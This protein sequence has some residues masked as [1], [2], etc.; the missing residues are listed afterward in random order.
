MNKTVEKKT[1]KED[2]SDVVEETEY[3]RRERKKREKKERKLERKKS[4]VDRQES[5]DANSD[6]PDDEFS[7]STVV[8]THTDS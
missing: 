6:A 8:G 3:E 7:T 5:M 4:G 2:G 1:E